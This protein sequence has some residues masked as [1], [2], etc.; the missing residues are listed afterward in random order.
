M[1]C[2]G[3]VSHQSKGRNSGRS[4]GNFQTAA[5]LSRCGLL[6][7]DASE[8]GTEAGSLRYGCHFRRDNY[9]VSKCV[10]VYWMMKL[11][12]QQRVITEK[13]VGLADG[14]VLPLLSF[15]IFEPL[16]WVRHCFTT[17]AG[18]VSTG[19]YESLNLSFTRGDD[20]EAVM[21]NYRRVAEAM[22][23]DSAHIVTSDQTHT[24]NVRRVDASDAGKGIVCAR[25]YTDVDGLV[26]DQPGLLLA[27]FYADCVPL[28]FVDPVHHAIGLS[29]S[30][31]R[32]TKNRMGEVTV[33][34]MQECFGTKPQ[35]LLCAIGPSIC[36]SCYEVSEDVADE[37]RQ[38]FAHHVD[39][40]LI[41]KEHKKYQLDLWRANA[42]VLEDAG[43][44]PEH[45]ATTN[46]CTC[47]NPKLLFSHRASCGKRGNL[48]AFLM[49]A[50]S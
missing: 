49:I 32:G 27:T 48:G 23:T 22:G 50:D 21:E 28:Y 29:H 36:Q 41:P 9:P 12:N 39:E 19:I 20:P 10:P 2:G 13:Q 5:Y 31:W 7:V 8:H 33:Q 43:V 4:G 6:F 14:H 45:I 35:E 38:T 47:C 26:T 34:K 37:F 3:E 15:S 46:I 11:T 42:I 16:P 44:L 24:V 40:I 30:G 17:R 25:D 18:G 1:L